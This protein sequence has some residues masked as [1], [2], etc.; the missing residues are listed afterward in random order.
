MPKGTKLQREATRL[1]AA[2]NISYTAALRRLRET[3]P[4]QPDP[5]PA[6]TFRLPRILRLVNGTQAWLRLLDQG[7]RGIF[8]LGPTKA[9]V[10]AEIR[11]EHGHTLI[12]GDPDTGKTNLLQLPLLAAAHQVDDLGVT[13]CD[14]GRGEPYFWTRRLVN[15][16]EA[17]GADDEIPDTLA[18]VRDRVVYFR[19]KKMV[20]GKPELLVIDEIDNLLQDCDSEVENAKNLLDILTWGPRVGVHVI[21]TANSVTRGGL[22]A[23]LLPLFGSRI[24]L[25]KPAN[26][27]D[28]TLF[29]RTVETNPAYHGRGWLQHRGGETVQFHTYL[30]ETTQPDF[31][32]ITH[33]YVELK[34][35]TERILWLAHRLR[36]KDLPRI[37]AALAEEYPDFE[38]FDFDTESHRAVLKPIPETDVAAESA[39]PADVTAATARTTKG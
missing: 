21:A 9:R 2:E 34:Y 15:F 8:P 22:L 26:S 29:G 36:P 3:P 23:D 12:V 38:V 27:Q 5:G 13:V 10:Q 24:L 19:S 16:V 31:V 37:T 6:G 30:P 7:S 1:A 20:H 14:A 39:R 11:L 4:P 28:F 35:A 17:E 33:E 25:G 32:D 18:A